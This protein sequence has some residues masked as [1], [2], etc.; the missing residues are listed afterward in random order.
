MSRWWL[1]GVWLLALPALGQTDSSR[2]GRAAGRFDAIPSGAPAHALSVEGRGSFD[3]NVLYNDL[4]LGL[5]N[6]DRLSREVRE[7]SQDALTGRERGGYAVD[8]AVSYAWGQGLFGRPQWRP[9]VRVAYHSLL[10]LRFRDPVYD[11]T[12]FGNA[13]WEGRTAK[14]DP[15][16]FERIDYQT[17]AF[18]VEDRRSGSF[19]EVAVVNGRSLDA[20]RIDRAALT[21]GTEGRY[22]DLDLDGSYW[23]SDTADGGPRRSNGIGAAVGFGMQRPIQ[24]GRASGEFAFLVQDLGFI[25]WD[26]RSLRVSRDTLIHYT[27]LRVQDVLDLEGLIVGRNSLQD[28]LGLGYEHGAFI[29]ML[30]TTLR[31]RVGLG[32]LRSALFPH[33]FA[34]E[35]AVEQRVLP[36]YVPLVSLRR[37]FAAG[38]DLC[39]HAE[40][41]YGGFGGLRAGVG[42]KARLFR[43]ALL[44]VAS[45]NVIGTA[46]GSARGKAV[47]AGLDVEW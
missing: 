39:V 38:R 15:S 33:T 9:R 10:G 41:V 14:L 1:C 27:G 17:L 36:G 16:A 21:T 45:P 24:V 31:S 23:R 43:H 11:L 29:R 32:R 5:Y 20:A 12:F 26:N 8:L 7:R 42:V 22:L 46:S 2:Y 37:T 30:P 47:L 13:D 25:A 19:I 35:L 34:Y 28:T 3:S 6:G 4:V 18:G 44:T 40:A